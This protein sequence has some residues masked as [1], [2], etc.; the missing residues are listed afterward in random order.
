MIAGDTI[1]NTLME[2]GEVLRVHY[3]KDQS[4]RKADLSINYLGWVTATC[5]LSMYT[6]LPVD[7]GLIMERAIITTLATSLTMRRLYWQQRS[8]Q[9]RQEYP[10]STCRYFCNTII[11]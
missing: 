9:K 3:G 7:T 4:Y 1:T 10:T 6:H 5:M 11:M 8:S 2:Y